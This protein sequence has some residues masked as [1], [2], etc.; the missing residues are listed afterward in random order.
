MGDILLS[1]ERPEPDSEDVEPEP[2]EPPEPSEPPEPA[3]EPGPPE[4]VLEDAEISGEDASEHV[5]EPPVEPG[6]QWIEEYEAEKKE[7][8][9]RRKIPH[10][11]AMIAAV[12][13]VLIV[14]IW[15][16]LSPE[17]LPEVGG[18]YLE[19]G[20]YANLGS[21]THTLDLRWLFE[22]IYVA[23]TVWGVSISGSPN[24][25][26]DSPATFDVL[27]TKVSED[28]K[29][30]WFVGTSI[31][32][33]DVTMFL[34]DGPQIGDMIS[35]SAERFGHIGTVEATFDSAGD[36]RCYVFVEITIYGKMIIGYLPV[37]IL[38]MNT[39]FDV[40]IH[41]E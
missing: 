1:S 24:A 29:N 13:I 6:E 17:V 5:T 23:D 26:V 38:R 33:N 2:P 12:V 22:S 28:M 21:D 16:L 3:D 20:T 25:S 27:V 39:Y 40:D 10:L 4:P 7:K 41:V 36:H 9:P 34:D 14:V 18:T 31:K 15:T 30:A 35:R 19:S 32:L 8:K 37:K 11:G